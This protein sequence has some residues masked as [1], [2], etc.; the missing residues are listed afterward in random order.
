[1]SKA[2]V[3]MAAAAFLA[4]GSA[5]FAAS[6]QPATNPSTDA[7]FDTISTLD[8]AVFGAFN[9]CSDPGQLQKHASYFAPDIEFYHDNGGVTWTRKAMI[10]NTAKN[11]CGHYRRELVPGSLKVYPIKGFGAIEQGV[12]RFCM[13]K[14]GA[15]EGMADFVIV[16]R[17]QGATWQITRVL[18]YGHRSSE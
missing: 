4:I 13:L 2:T 15:C 10:A 16:W 12:H 11:V 6:Q 7:L 9:H 5:A 3:L 17:H 14:T 1:M 8:T 18:S